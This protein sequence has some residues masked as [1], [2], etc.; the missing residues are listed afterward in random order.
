MNF[1]QHPLS[2]AFPSMSETDI[3]ALAEDI[4]KHG[5][6][7]PGV[8][9]EGMVL[10]GWHRF[11]AC[12]RAGVAF[13]SV[14]FE[15][16][17]PIAFVLAKNLHRRHLTASQRAAAIV[18]AHNWRPHGDQSRSA[19]AADRTMKTTQEMAREAEVSPRTIEHAKAA[20]EAG[21]GDAVKEGRVSAERAAQVAKLPKAKREKALDA[22]EPRKPSA[23]AVKARADLIDLQGKYA[24]LLEKHADLAQTARDLEDKLTKLEAVEPDDQQKLIEKLQKRI[25]R[26]EA[27]VERITRARNDAQTKNNE[28]IREVKRLQKKAK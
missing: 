1:R 4:R 20:Q 19:A 23:D 8:M 28:L 6:R 17:D 27:E 11:L 26:L 5:Q 10:D 21:L 24:D 12:D 15:G 3:E 7:D 22:P 9:F 13:E 14:E 25:V 18:A 16:T 2:A